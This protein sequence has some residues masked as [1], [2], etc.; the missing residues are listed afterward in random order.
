[1]SKEEYE[2][3]H[4]ELIKL[5]EQ[6]KED[7]DYIAKAIPEIEKALSSATYE[8]VSEC[9]EKLGEI[10]DELESKLKVIEMVFF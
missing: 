1:M 6:L 7:A 5:L 2:K 8:T 9:D 4:A 3:R 10:F